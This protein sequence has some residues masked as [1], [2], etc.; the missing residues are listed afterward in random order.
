LSYSNSD[1][2]LTYRIFDPDLDDF[3]ADEE[4]IDE[5][6]PDGPTYSPSLVVDSN[7]EVHIVYPYSF[8][9]SGA[10]N[11]G[12]VNYV[13]GNYGNWSEVEFLQYWQDSGIVDSFST[14]PVICIDPYYDWLWIVF[15]NLRGVDEPGMGYYQLCQLYKPSGGDWETYWITKPEG[16]GIPDD[17]PGAIVYNETPAYPSITHR[18][19][20]GE[21]GYIVPNSYFSGYDEATETYSAY[22]VGSWPMPP[23]NGIDDVDYTEIP[24]AT[25]LHQNYPNPFN[26]TT[27]IGF[28]LPEE[29]RVELNVYDVSGKLVKTLVEG[30]KE[31]AYHTV[32]WNGTDNAGKVLPSGVYVYT[33]KAGNHSES[34]TMILLR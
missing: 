31:A 14:F 18:V 21:N 10:G 4:V 2:D 20:S 22:V 16:E 9:E 11:L 25:N 26:P 3:T 19:P 17:L 7:D 28:E 23:V 30:E 12:T 34:K 6:P 27:E 29:G 24:S 32:Y 13:H 1:D 5:S 33:L 8:H 15:T